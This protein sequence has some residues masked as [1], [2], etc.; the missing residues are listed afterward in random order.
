MRFGGRGLAR[1]CKRLLLFPGWRTQIDGINV[2]A[3][4]TGREGLITFDVPA[5]KH[6][7]AIAYAGT[8]LE[9]TADWIA[10]ASG[11]LVLGVGAAAIYV[12][13]HPIRLSLNR[14]WLTLHPVDAARSAFSCSW[15]SLCLH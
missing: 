9:N 11:L 10:L 5:G 6:T 4:P 12:V 15:R 1:S 14:H 2:D 13:G 3:R 8:P 7:L